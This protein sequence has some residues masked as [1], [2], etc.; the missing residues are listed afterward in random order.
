M[1]SHL[2][3]SHNWVRLSACRLFGAYF[4]TVPAEGVF[5]Q[6]HGID[7]VRGGR[8]SR[9][10]ADDFLKRDSALYLVGKHLTRQLESQFLD[11]TLTDQARAAGGTAHGDSM[12]AL[13]NLFFVGK[14]LS[15]LHFAPAAEHEPEAAV[16]GD[17]SDSEAP[18]QLEV[19]V[20]DW[21][22]RDCHC[23]AGARQRPGLSVPPDGVHLPLRVAAL[24]LGAAALPVSSMTASAEH[25]ASRL[26]S[27]VVRCNGLVPTRRA[28]CAV[29]ATCTA[30][31]LPVRS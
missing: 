16:G 22:L 1:Q 19:A 3:Y 14:A 8:H 4:A 2:L 17:D 18:V 7:A 30:A 15:V 31:H 13:K 23:G 28:L 20:I 11:D 29:H 5:T 6:A 27:A 21:L 9:A 12:Q 26:L 10:V 24:Q 25:N